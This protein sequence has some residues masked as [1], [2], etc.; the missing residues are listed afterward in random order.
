MKPKKAVWLIIIVLCLGS[1]WL[2][3]PRKETPSADS[4]SEASS[5]PAVA[6]QSSNG[7]NSPDNFSE[8]STSVTE[9]KD[10]FTLREAEMKQ[11]S[12]EVNNQWRAPI[13][14]YGKVVDQNGNPVFGANIAFGLNNLDGQSTIETISDELG[15]FSLTGRQGKHLSVR[16]GKEGYSISKLNPTGFFYAGSNEDFV[17]DVGNPVTFYLYKRGK[18]EPL[19]RAEARLKI[20]LKGQSTKIDLAAGKVAPSGGDM[21]IVCV[22]DYEGRATNRTFDWHMKITASGGIIESAKEFDFVAPEGVYHPTVEISMPATMTNGWQEVVERKFFLKLANG[23]FARVSFRF[24]SY[25]GVLRL[26]S[27]VN[28]SGSR[29]LEYDPAVQPKP[30]V[31]E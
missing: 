7:I 6:E 29:N 24:Y 21:E 15:L 4:T 10:F 25:N 14:F 12:E 3:R 1:V 9:Q 20:P 22:S 8:Q 11:T 31:F 30:T 2:L 17:P 5:V 26:E 27:F 23:N 16:I 19:L 13:D 18:A 28:P